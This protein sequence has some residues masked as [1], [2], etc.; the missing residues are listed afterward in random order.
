MMRCIPR[1]DRETRTELRYRIGDTFRFPLS[2]L[3][4]EEE[5]YRFRWVIVSFTMDG[6]ATVKRLHDG[7]E[8]NIA[9]YWLDRYATSETGA[10][11][12]ART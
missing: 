8:K 12:Q 7:V 11:M 9:L 5:V 1:C 10:E 6:L 4:S 2:R 3:G